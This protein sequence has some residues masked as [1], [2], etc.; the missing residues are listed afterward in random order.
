MGEHPITV[1]TLNN[2]SSSPSKGWKKS[3]MGMILTEFD[4][5]YE[6]DEMDGGGGV[7]RSNK[8][9]RFAGEGHD[10]N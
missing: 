6:D 10:A 3:G 7:I 4:D 9:R 8:V 1:N 5:A 2:V